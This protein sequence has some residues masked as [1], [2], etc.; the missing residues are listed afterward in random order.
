MEEV[1]H[2]KRERAKARVL[3]CH[4]IAYQKLDQVREF[5]FSTTESVVTTRIKIV[6]QEDFMFA[7]SLQQH[8]T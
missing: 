1:S 3:T 2:R 5:A 6:V 7:G 4:Q 8:L